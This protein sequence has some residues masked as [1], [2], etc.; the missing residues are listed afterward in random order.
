MNQL[1]IQ[2]LNLPQK[3]KIEFSTLL[4]N[5]EKNRAFF[6]F[7]LVFEITVSRD[8]FRPQPFVPLCI[9]NRTKGLLLSSHSAWL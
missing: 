9:Q 8:L 7:F 5:T 1:K 3:R 6:F 2:S 4:V